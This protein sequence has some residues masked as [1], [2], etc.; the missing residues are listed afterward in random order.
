MGNKIFHVFLFLLFLQQLPAQDFPLPEMQGYKRLTNY[1]VFLPETLWD[2]IDGAADNYLAYAFQ[3]LHVAEYKK[4]K[5]VIK[6]EIYRHRD[7]INAFGI[8]SS[9][10]SPSFEFI[11]IGAQG[12]KTGGSL[13]FFKGNYYVKIRTYSKSE[14][15][16]QAVEILARKT[17]N[18]LEGDKVMPEL[19]SLFP[20]ENKKKNEELYINESVLGHKFLNG[21]LK[22]M[23]ED[24]GSTFYIHLFR[25]SSAGDIRKTAET[26]LKS[27]GVEPVNNGDDKYMFTD[28]YNGNIFLSFRN[29]LM[30][31]ITGLAKDQADIAGRYS[32]RI[33][34]QSL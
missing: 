5:N 26:Y 32:S 22:A 10:R 12:Y 29:N 1:P 8:Y 18:M 25:G 13:N 3:D 28:G 6:L 19:L 34:N 17:E 24:D 2:F 7:N 30:V 33:L 23:Y 20:A 14:K 31:I 27:A 4:G 21:A 9:E 16:L 11:N 15:V